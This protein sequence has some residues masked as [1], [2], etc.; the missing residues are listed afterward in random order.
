MPWVTH[1]PTLALAAAGLLLLQLLF[2][3]V[4][5]KPHNELWA[6]IDTVGVPPG[7]GII[8]WALA[9]AKSVTSMQETMREGYEKFSKSN[10]PFALPTMWMG[11]ALVVLP[12]SMLHLL[13]KPRDELSS[14][15]ALLENAQFQYLMT[16][17]DVWGNTIHFDIVRKN[18]TQKD[19]VPLAG[20]MAEEW[21]AAFRTCWG[22]SKGGMVVNA[23]DS[24]VRIIARVALRIMVGLPGCRDENYLEQSRLYANAVLV[25]ACFINC[26]PPAVR[27]V[28]GRLVALR[29]RYHQRKLLKILVPMVEERMRQCEEKEGQDDGPV[30]PT[31]SISARSISVATFSSN[32]LLTSRAM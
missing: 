6:K 32:H 25:D 4:R 23:W 16:D 15:D 12:P 1:L 9:I 13:N 27:P 24:M 5:G 14:F 28:A 31:L 22:D 18:L 21:D 2:V 8:S 10:K 20:I 11:G 19:M 30:C 26:L 29:A 3:I 17:K 7:G